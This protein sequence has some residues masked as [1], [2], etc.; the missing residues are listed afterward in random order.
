VLSYFDLIAPEG[1]WS[2]AFGPMLRSYA[3]EVRRDAL[4]LVVSVDSLLAIFNAV[5]GHAESTE[6]TLLLEAALSAIDAVPADLPPAASSAR[7]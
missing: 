3:D 5:D 2:P 4:P 1:R 7:E 6:F